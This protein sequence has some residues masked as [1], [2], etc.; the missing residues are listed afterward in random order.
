MKAVTFHEHGGP[1]KLRYE[2]VPVPSIGPD[3]V[4]VRVK[5]CAVNHLDIWIR[6][7]IPA[8]KLS[9][10]HIPGAD[11]AGV[12]ESTGSAVS[13]IVP[14]D[15][16]VVSPGLSCFRCPFCLAGDDNLCTTYR[17]IG[18]QVNGGYAEFV[19]VPAVNILPMPDNLTFEEAAAYPLTFL[20]AWH[21][22][23]GRAGIRPGQD[24]LILAGGSGLGS[25][26]IQIAKLA[27][28]RIFTTAG[29]DRK[30]E[31]AKS[32]GADFGIPYERE[33]FSAR[34]L[35]MTDGRGVDVV[36]D[37]VGAATW[38]KSLA[39]LAKNGILL[40]CGT[41]TGG[42]V[43]MNIR[44]LFMRQQTILGSTMGRRAELVE[45]TRLM[46]T[47]R[48]KAIIDSIYPLEKAREAQERML[49]RENFGKIVLKID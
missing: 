42:D 46:G 45:I 8:Y 13:G 27:G 15:K 11:I 1:E 18:A 32:L 43:Q 26:A 9:L 25:A 28:A 34:V 44:P 23:I 33:D 39:S 10:P 2:D 19:S 37:H 49:N 20:T 40:A 12:V 14:G 17:I 5:A 48:L 36:F 38:G 4:L 41:T 30:L 21:L 29:S 47:G 35:E 7:G 6:Q 16:V 3:N 24:V 31:Q 22:L